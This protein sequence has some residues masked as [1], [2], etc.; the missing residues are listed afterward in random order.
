MQLEGLEA[1]RDRCATVERPGAYVVSGLNT[2][3]PSR[4][5][6]LSLDL[7]SPTP[8]VLLLQPG[9]L[10]PSLLLGLFLPLYSLCLSPGITCLHVFLITVSLTSQ[11]PSE[12]LSLPLSLCLVQHSLL[13]FF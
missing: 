6:S 2:T 11:L 9:R 13:L 7:I 10:A 1:L 8:L 5:S 12:N 4:L 3:V